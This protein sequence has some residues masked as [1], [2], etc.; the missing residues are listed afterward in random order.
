MPK[1]V[2]E[3][4]EEARKI[5]GAAMEIL[6]LGIYKHFIRSTYS[7]CKSVGLSRNEGC[8]PH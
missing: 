6:V 3:Y 2:L 4:K 8:P 1:V 7:V 5:L